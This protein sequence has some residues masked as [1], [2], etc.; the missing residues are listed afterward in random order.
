M[1]L[2]AGLTPQ[3][4][5]RFCKEQQRKTRAGLESHNLAEETRSDEKKKLVE[6]K[7]STERGL[8]EAKQPNLP[9]TDETERLTWDFPLPLF[10]LPGFAAALERD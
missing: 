3:E 1:G 8:L 9:G 4:V 7:K 10:E 5:S 2:D 6:T